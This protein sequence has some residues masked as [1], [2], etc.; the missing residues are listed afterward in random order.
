MC[1]GKAFHLILMYFYFLFSMLWGVFSKIRLFFI[2]RCFSRFSIDPICFSINGNLFKNLSEPL[3]GL[4]D[5]NYFLI[6]RTSWIWFFKNGSWLFQK[7][8]FFKSF[9]SFL[10]LSDLD[11]APP[12]SF[13]VL[14]FPFARFLS[15]NTSKTLLP[16][17]L[18]L[19]SHFM[20]FHA[21]LIWEFWT[22]HNLGFLMI[23]A[24]SCVIDHWVLL[25]YCYIHDLCWK[26]WSIWRFVKNQNF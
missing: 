19:F 14:I 17:F 12:Q 26:I 10:S 20:H 2:N 6:N 21:F 24:K 16:F 1:F 8:F 3:F 25:L 23:Q 15:P 7:Q 11:L 9:S 13:V 4:I 5:R 22:M 18:F